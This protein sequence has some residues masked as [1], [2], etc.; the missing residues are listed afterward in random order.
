MRFL[1]LWYTVYYSHTGRPKYL[2]LVQVKV[3]TEMK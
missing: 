3:C 1:F 2:Q